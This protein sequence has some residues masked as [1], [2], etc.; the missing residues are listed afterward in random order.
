MELKLFGWAPGGVG[1]GVVPI[2]PTDTLLFHASMPFISFFL[3][4]N[5][6]M[7]HS[8]CVFPSKNGF[9]LLVFFLFA[10]SS[11]T[12]LHSSPIGHAQAAA[13]AAIAH[14]RRRAALHGPRRRQWRLDGAHRLGSRVHRHHHHLLL[15]PPPLPRRPQALHRWDRSIELQPKSP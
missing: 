15:P 2:K 7:L 12:H 9:S 11:Y 4:E 6:F 14:T 3:K 1:A 10:S 5:V 13:A 8:P